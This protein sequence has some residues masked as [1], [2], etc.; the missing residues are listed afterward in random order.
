VTAVGARAWGAAALA[1]LLALAA[2][3]ARAAAPGTGNAIEI[4]AADAAPII[5][6]A[7]ETEL[8]IEVPAAGAAPGGQ[9]PAPRLWTSVGRL[10]GVTRAGP[11]SFTARYLL[12]TTRFPQV[13]IIA[14]ELPAAAPAPAAPCRGYLALRLRATASPGFRTDPGASVTVRVAERD[15]GP[16]VAAADG[17]VRVSVVVPPG[18]R[19]AVARSVSTFGKTTEQPLDLAPPPFPR[20]LVL[21]PPALVTGDTQEIA[22]VGVEPTG[23][24]LDHGRIALVGS[25]GRPHPLGGEPG[26]ARFL[27]RVPV[28]LETRQL[29]LNALLKGEPDTESEARVPLEP[30]PVASL[31]IRPERARLLFGERAPSEVFII[32]RDQHGNP[33]PARPLAMYVDGRRTATRPLPDG[34]VAVEVHAPARFAGRNALLIEAVSPQAY[35]RQEIA[36]ALGRPPPVAAAVPPWTLTPRLGLLVGRGGQ[37]GTAAALDGAAVVPP[38]APLALDVGLSLGYLGRRLRADDGRGLSEVS[39]DQALLLAQLRWTRPLGRLTVMPGAGVGP[40]VVWGRTRQGDAAMSGRRLTAAFALGAELS[41]P[42]GPGALSAGGRFVYLPLGKLS[43]GNA[44]VG[45]GGGLV[46][47]LGYRVG[48]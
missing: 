20:L 21:A 32:A 48:L 7:G 15:F 18:V 27:I 22:V 1:G 5:G 10:E 47:D 44:L 11:R 24:P 41:A 4:T 3:A 26:L 37:L 13:A 14:A 23:D 39:V 43:D 34:R 31:T 9:A 8:R 25:Y 35:A 45:N 16:V 46:L 38:L 36:L 42:L 2:G 28:S 40:A 30:G 6:L 12:P 29:R 33:A 17:E 19:A